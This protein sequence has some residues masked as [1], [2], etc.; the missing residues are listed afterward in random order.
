QPA[1]TSATAPAAR[2]RIFMRVSS[3]APT[4][5]AHEERNHEGDEEHEEQDL[6][7][8]GRARGDAAEAEDR[9]DQSDDEEHGSPV[10]HVILL[11]GLWSVSGGSV[12]AASAASMR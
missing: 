5:H 6:G 12:G 11:S 8:P 2:S 1:A 9:G 3:D 10:K 7:D 4:Q